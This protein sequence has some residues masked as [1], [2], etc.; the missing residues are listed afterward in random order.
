MESL[1]FWVEKGTDLFSLTR[2]K[3]QKTHFHS[4]ST[5][6]QQLVPVICLDSVWSRPAASSFLISQQHL[7]TV[8]REAQQGVKLPTGQRLPTGIS[9]HRIPAQIHRQ[10]DHFIWSMVSGQ[11]EKGCGRERGRG[12]GRAHVI[13]SDVLKPHSYK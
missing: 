12:G 9:V 1:H 6:L 7:A 3:V 11:R 2:H 5:S 10:T 8:G 4:N 13:S